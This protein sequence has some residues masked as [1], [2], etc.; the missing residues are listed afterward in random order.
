MKNSARYFCTLFQAP[1]VTAPHLLGAHE[2]GA[3]FSGAILD[4]VLLHHAHI[5]NEQRL[6]LFALNGLP[7]AN[8]S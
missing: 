4:P 5:E 2:E 6:K 3:P 8:G 1:A 7:D